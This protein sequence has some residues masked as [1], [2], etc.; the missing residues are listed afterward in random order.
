MYQLEL[1]VHFVVGVGLGQQ[2]LLFFDFELDEVK[3]HIECHGGVEL[4]DI[5]ELFEEVPHDDVDQL[6]V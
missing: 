6:S 3:G 1:V 2:K 4:S 5:D